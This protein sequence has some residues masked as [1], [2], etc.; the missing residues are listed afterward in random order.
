MHQYNESANVTDL[1]II[2]VYLNGCNRNPKPLKRLC[3][4]D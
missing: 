3:K 1:F 2:Q 4:K